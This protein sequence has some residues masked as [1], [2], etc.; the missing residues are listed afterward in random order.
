MAMRKG[1][2]IRRT[3]RSPIRRRSKRRTSRKTSKPSS[4]G[5]KIY[6]VVKNASGYLAF[7]SQL[8]AKDYSDLNS[9]AS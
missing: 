6:S 4:A 3:L 2:A 5:S 9:Q 8:T 1:K 7:A